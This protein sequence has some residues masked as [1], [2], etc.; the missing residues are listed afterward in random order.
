MDAV[1]LHAAQE[2]AEEKPSV[3]VDAVHVDEPVDLAVDA[4][5]VDEPIDLTV[6]EPTT[7][8]EQPLKAEPLLTPSGDFFIY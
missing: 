5:H 4:V 2:L 1:L 3:H 6:D 7:A 8:N